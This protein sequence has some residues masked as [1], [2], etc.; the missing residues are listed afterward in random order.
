MNASHRMTNRW[1]IALMILAGLVVITAATAWSG[2][3]VLT[4]LPIGFLFGFF[5]QKGD[6]CGSSAFSEVVMMKDW[7]KVFGLW[8]VIVTAMSGFAALDL[9]GWI[10]LNP[11]PFLYLNV[12]VG[13]IVFG[14]GMV[15]A[16]GCISGCLYKAGAGNLNSMAALVGIPLGAMTVEYGPL[17]PL[18]QA[19]KQHVIETRDG[20]VA[21]LPNV[22]GLPYW[23]LAALCLMATVVALFLSRK[24]LKVK[25]HLTA[26]GESWFQRFMTSS[27]KPWQAGLAI[28]LLMIPAYVS[29]AASGRNYPLG[30]KEGV[31]HLER[32]LIDRDLEQIWQAPRSTPKISADLT[33]PPVEAGGATRRPGK[34]VVWW[35]VGL[36]VSLVLGSHAA[37]RLSGRARLLPKPPDE[38]ITAFGGGLLV[39][40]GT[41]FGMGCVVG[42]ILSGWALMSLGGLLFGLVTILMN[43]ITTYFYMMGGFATRAR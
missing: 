24:K 14:V 2:L 9:L 39:G 11:K 29:S 15:L 37:G 35:M 1:G 3:W 28:G 23:V 20:S 43:W 26:G 27:W 30:A 7:R 4:C 22:L 40:V 16:G 5:L 33:N 21:S 25:Q 38:T 6:L 13:G 34:K 31:V 19:M 8:V 17:Y 12:I 10:E 41:A 32:L 36:V 42:N 18:Q